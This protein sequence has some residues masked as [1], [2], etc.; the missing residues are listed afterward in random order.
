MDILNTL[1][2]F[3]AGSANDDWNK[4][5]WAKGASLFIPQLNQ[6]LDQTNYTFT[7]TPVE[8][9]QQNNI[10]LPL[11]ELFTKH[12]SDKSSRHN[13]HIVYAFLLDKLG[14]EQPLRLLEIGLGTNNPGLVSTM[15]I[16]GK[17]G[18][19][20]YAFREYLQN[21]T[22]Y[23]GDIDKNILFESER[24]H[25]GFVDQLDIQT[26]N[27]LTAKFGQTTYDVIIDD[28]LHSIGANFNTLLFGLS[29]LAD[30]GWIIIEDIHI[31]DNWRA[32]DY[33]LKTTNKYETYIVKT[34]LSYV[35][36]VHK[37]NSDIV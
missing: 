36:V 1:T 2:C 26:F 8:Y 16:D 12:G 29:H 3:S 21:A 9:F 24:I 14:V 31:V 15:G 20:L 23:G 6:L 33:I 7:I 22:I 4:H 27:T 18:A 34:A 35:Y 11:G 17:P 37:P 13:Y 32:I 30:N 5:L 28:G 25:T 10:H 19:S